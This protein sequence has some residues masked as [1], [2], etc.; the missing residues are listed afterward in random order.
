MERFAVSR[1]LPMYEAHYETVLAE[2][3][4]GRRDAG[5]ARRR[6]GDLVRR[7]LPGPSPGRDGV[8]PRLQL[9]SPGHGAGGPWRRGAGAGFRGS[10]C[11][12]PPS[13]RC[14]WST[15]S[16]SQRCWRG[17]ARGDRTQLRY[18][19]LLLVASVPA[20]VAGVGFGDSFASL[21]DSPAVTGAALLVMGCALWTARAALDRGPAGRPELGSAVAVGLA[22]AVA[23]VPGIS[24]SGTTVVAALWRGVGP[25]EAAAFSF[26]LSVP[27]V[28]GAGA[29]GGAR[30]GGG[31]CGGRRRMGC[32]WGCWGRGGGGRLHNGCGGYWGRSARVLENRSLHPLRTVSVGGG[33][34]SSSASWAGGLAGG[35]RRSPDGPSTGAWGGRP[36]EEWAK[37]MSVATVEFHGR[38][39]STSDRARALVAEGLPRPAV[40]VA[41]RQ[42]AGRGRRG[43]DWR[44]GHAAGAVVHRRRRSGGG[45]RR[46]VAAQGGVGGGAGRGVGGAGP[47]GEDQ[48][49]QR[50]AG[51]GEEAGR[52]SSANRL[53]APSSPGVG[54]NLNHAPDDLPA[55]PG[56]AHHLDS[57]RVRDPRVPRPGF[58]KDR[59]RAPGDLGAPRGTDFRRGAG[60]VGGALSAPRAKVGGRRRGAPF[61]GAPAR[62]RGACGNRGEHPSRRHAS[63]CATTRGGRWRWSPGRSDGT[64]GLPGAEHGLPVGR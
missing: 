34:R 14:W 49:A 30:T 29:V 46:R 50:P 62:R 44:V 56:N 16:G 17:V 52:R 26:L 57:H 33:G 53:E 27:A 12:S 5:G 8:S 40:V 25:R 60:G 39:G 45:E 11:I 15:G 32:R 4:G 37:R 31:C 13:C 28:G 35:E 20:A 23:M 63:G 55:G 59:R 19:G 3:G 18:G 58:G 38:I 47:A 54:V 48:V 21:F 61:F 10:R 22:Q 24:R 1:I 36:A 51:R 7:G 9:G 2:A 43:R 6:R 42:S 64:L 41:D